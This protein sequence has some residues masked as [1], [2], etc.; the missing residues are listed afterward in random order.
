MLHAQNSWKRQAHN[1][2]RG[3]S[4]PQH[5]S[6]ASQHK[7]ETRKKFVEKLHEFTEQNQE[8]AEQTFAWG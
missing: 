3:N 1:R 7:Q 5:R 6:Y 2:W 8:V 4:K